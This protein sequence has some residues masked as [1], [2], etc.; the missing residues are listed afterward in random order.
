VKTADGDD[1]FPGA[2]EA[3]ATAL[4]FELQAERSLRFRYGLTDDNGLTNPDPGL[5]A[6]EVTEDR[7]PVLELDLGSD[8]LLS[9]IS[10]WG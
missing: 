6:I 5:W 4:G 1:F 8:T 2:A 7:A 9:E 10:V 3:S